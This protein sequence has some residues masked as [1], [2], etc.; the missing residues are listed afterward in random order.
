[1]CLVGGGVG[2]GGGVVG[3]GAVVVG[4]GVVLAV[5]VSAVRMLGEM[6]LP[7]PEQASQPGPAE[8]A[9]LLPLVMSWK[10]VGA[11]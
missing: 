2:G 1:L 4:G 10:A 3:G 7:S 9:P 5:P 11:A 8:N 6:G